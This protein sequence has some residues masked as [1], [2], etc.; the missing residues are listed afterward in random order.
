MR[1]DSVVIVPS[2]SFSLKYFFIG[3]TKG[4]LRY[5]QLIWQTSSLVSFAFVADWKGEI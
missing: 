2:I 4:G 5:S 3:K 1:V